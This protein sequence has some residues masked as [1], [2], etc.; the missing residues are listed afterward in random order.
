MSSEAGSPSRS[1]PAGL[2]PVWLGIGSPRPQP[3][4]K[5]NSMF[6][7]VVD[8]FDEKSI[9]KIGEVT[10]YEKRMR[11]AEEAAAAAA[12]QKVVYEEIAERER[13]EME[14]LREQLENIPIK[15]DE[16]GIDGINGT[17]T[18]ADSVRPPP[19]SVLDVV[20]ASWLRIPAFVY[21][22]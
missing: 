6:G 8:A 17:G 7:H 21:C 14:Q 3:R 12:A 15:A 5:Q 13:K 16:S 4:V 11:A 19:E 2:E 9:V 1:Q 18:V 10:P 22:L 20:S